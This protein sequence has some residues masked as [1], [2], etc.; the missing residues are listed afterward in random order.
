MKTACK[1]INRQEFGFFLK[2]PY[3]TVYNKLG[4]LKYKKDI[5]KKISIVVSSKHE[6]RAVKRNKIK[7]R[8]INLYQKSKLSGVVIFYVSK[9][10]YNIQYD[11]TKSL[12]EDLLGKI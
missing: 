1:R 5:N 12:F 10:S 2:N 6:K 7:R 9:Q 4:T 11:E 3:K 8:L